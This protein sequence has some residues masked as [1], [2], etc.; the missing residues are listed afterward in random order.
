MKANKSCYVFIAL[1]M[2]MLAACVKD[3]DILKSV[4][5]HPAPGQSDS[6]DTRPTV[7]SCAPDYGDS[8][9]CYQLLSSGQ[10]YKISPVN[11]PGTRGRYIAE[12]DGL[13]IDNNTG[14]INVTKSESGLAY[15][16][17]FIAEGSTDT[18]FTKVI[19]SGI[20]YMDG[21]HI[22]GD[23]DTLAIPVYNGNA[24]AYPVCGT[25]GL[26][27]NCEFDDDEDDDNGNGTADEPPPGQTCS[28]KNI[29]VDKNTGVIKLK[30]SVLDGLFGLLP[31]NGTTV[32][33]TL[34]YR[35]G[36]C[37]NKALRRIDLRL[38]YY[39]KLS[40]V[41]Q[42]LIDDI[43][44]SVNSILKFLL[45]SQDNTKQANPRPPHIVVVAN[46]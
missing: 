37:S 16:V 7:I 42:L 14:T 23:N 29:I 35:L 3:L 2:L 36:D 21:I 26:F 41:P 34:Y 25:G 10:D 45:R 1:S 43:T 40:D 8:I 30:R 15:K 22:L 17:G 24:N 5:R 28:S 39:T 46:R 31:S 27:S 11:N 19:T 32:N 4:T 13:V 44:N 18:C 33:A 38:T 20:N 6:S 12:P 9:L